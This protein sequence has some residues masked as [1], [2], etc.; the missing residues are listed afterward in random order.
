MKWWKT[1][2]H[3]LPKIKE[4]SKIMA[5][6]GGCSSM[7][8]HLTVDQ[9]VVGSTPISHP[10]TRA[11]QGALF[12]LAGVLGFLP[13]RVRTGDPSATQ[14][15]EPRRRLAF[16]LF[17]NHKRTQTKSIE[18]FTV[19]EHRYLVCCIRMDRPHKH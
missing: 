10:D 7:A 14:T 6:Y 16:F 2:K 19:D 1:F 4:H 18:V 15:P 9:V 8:E 17:F 11:S 5:Q 3:Y 12:L 13:L